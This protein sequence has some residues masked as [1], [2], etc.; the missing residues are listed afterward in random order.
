MTLDLPP[1]LLNNGSAWAHIFLTK[2]GVSPNP[3]VGGGGQGV[4]MSC[5]AAVG[6]TSARMLGM[7][8][9][10]EELRGGGWGVLYLI[11]IIG[12]VCFYI[13]FRLL[14]YI[15]MFVFFIRFVSYC[16]L[17]FLFVRL[18]VCL[19]FLDFPAFLISLFSVFLLS[20]FLAF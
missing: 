6:L 11:V 5:I 1:A 19:F 12:F 9:G 2:K 15:L 17:V 14:L 10:G 4:L 8:G 13:F 18:F 3:K 7:E 20:C 16:S